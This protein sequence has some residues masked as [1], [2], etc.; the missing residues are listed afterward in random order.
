[1]YQEKSGNPARNDDSEVR[2]GETRSKKEH[3]EK[4]IGSRVAR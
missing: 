2:E 3:R 1:M 4:D